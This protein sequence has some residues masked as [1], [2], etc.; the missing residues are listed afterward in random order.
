[1]P[2]LYL[3]DN[4]LD[5]LTET[6][7]IKFL[8]ECDLNN[9]KYIRLNDLS[10][11]L[12]PPLIDFTLLIKPIS[13]NLVQENFMQSLKSKLYRQG[14]NVIVD[15][16]P[17]IRT[18]LYDVIDVQIAVG[19]EE[20]YP[21][22]DF[23]LNLYYSLKAKETSINII[24]GLI[25]ELR[26][27]HSGLTSNI[28][29]YWK[30]LTNFKYYKFLFSEIPC[31]LLEFRT[32]EVL[33]ASLNE[34]VQSVSDNIS[35]IYGNKTSQSNLD[36]LEKCRQKAKKKSS[37]PKKQGLGSNKTHLTPKKI[38]KHHRKKN[39]V[40]S[41]PGDGPVK[42]FVRPITLQTPSH[43]NQYKNNGQASPIIMRSTFRKLSPSSEEQQSND[44]DKEEFQDKKK[45]RKIFL[46]SLKEL[47]KILDNW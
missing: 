2:K 15:P 39:S 37:P 17:D 40:L 26:N 9:L 10:W 34:V 11:Q 23:G 18:D 32:P 41:L 22:S 20:Y 3:N 42:Y 46:Q 29:S 36:K 44:L 31:V 13:N 19:I 30:H 16:S 21:L 25:K 28:A 7:L 35:C 43:Q 33:E 45:N 27:T 12:L 38:N 14:A 1:M 8:E 4:L 5:T 6:E 24:E 47:D